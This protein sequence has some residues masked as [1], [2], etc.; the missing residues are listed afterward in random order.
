MRHF[1]KYLL[2]VTMFF[3]FKNI[4]A[5]SLSVEDL[6]KIDKSSVENIETF[7]INKKFEFAGVEEC[8]L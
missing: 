6:V 2:L 4:T 3:V 1:Q 5:Q 8:T 7:L